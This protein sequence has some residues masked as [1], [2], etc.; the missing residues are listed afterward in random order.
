MTSRPLTCPDVVELVTDLLELALPAEQ[1][2]AVERHL[3]TC[4]GC[5]AYVEHLRLTVTLLR[6]HRAA[7]LRAAFRARA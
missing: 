1:L 2:L 6:G 5:D 4:D 3:A 7:A